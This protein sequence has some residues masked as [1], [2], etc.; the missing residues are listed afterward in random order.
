MF[1]AKRAVMPVG[2]DPL[3]SLVAALQDT[4]QRAGC[5]EPKLVDLIPFTFPN[6]HSQFRVEEGVAVVS[7]VGSLSG[8]VESDIEALCG[9]HRR[10]ADLHGDTQSTEEKEWR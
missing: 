2:T 1:V 3:L 7:C 4:S 6:L 8:R 9:L 10:S 5:G